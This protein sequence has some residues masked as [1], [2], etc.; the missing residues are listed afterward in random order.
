MNL[1]HQGGPL[2]KVKTG[3]FSM[4]NICYNIRKWVQFQ[5]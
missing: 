1:F 3:A 4:L 5:S 2:F